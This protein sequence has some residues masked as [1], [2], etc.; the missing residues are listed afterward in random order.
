R[1]GEMAQL[2]HILIRPNRTSSDFRKSMDR[3]DSVRSE[4]I[5]GKI[6]F[7]AAVAKYATDDMSARTGGMMLDPQTGSSELSID[8]LDPSLALMIDSLKIGGFSQPHIFVQENGER[9]TRIIYLKSLTDPHQ[10][11][12]RDDYSRIQQAAMQ[13]KR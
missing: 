6:G 7:G 3:L 12:L 8:Q 10:A 4:L 5:S 9:S 1:Q 2:R 13:Q 11:N